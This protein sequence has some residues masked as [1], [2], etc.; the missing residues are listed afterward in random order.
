M[1]ASAS[2]SPFSGRSALGVRIPAVPRTTT[3]PAHRQAVEE[4][5]ERRASRCRALPS[6][7]FP[8]CCVTVSSPQIGIVP[9]G[10]KRSTTACARICAGLQ[11]DQRR[12]E[13]AVIAAPVIIGECAGN[14]QQT[15]EPVP[16]N[17]DNRGEH[18][19]LKT[20][21]DRFRKLGRPVLQDTAHSLRDPDHRS[22]LARW[23]LELIRTV[24]LPTRR[25]VV[26]PQIGCSGRQTRANFE[27]RAT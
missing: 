6:T 17:A 12:L 4:C 1:S 15:A 3:P 14:V 18:Q 16:P 11:L 19:H 9:R 24:N 10:R 20:G 22:F 7:F 5:V 13:S 2:R 21:P 8:G 27:L 25:L 23:E 26:L